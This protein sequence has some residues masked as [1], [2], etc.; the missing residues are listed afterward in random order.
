MWRTSKG[1]VG[2]FWVDL[3]DGRIYAIKTSLREAKR[4]AFPEAEYLDC[5]ATHYRGWD[6]AKEMNPRWRDVAD[7]DTVPRGRVT[8]NIATGIFIVMATPSL[9]SCETKLREEFNLIG[10]R[11]IFLYD[12]IGYFTSSAQFEDL[13]K[14]R[15]A[16][17]DA[18]GEAIPR[19]ER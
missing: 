17:S 18:D 13:F 4:R 15:N 5:L 19:R 1:Y 3:E 9:K 12:V 11:F 14:E 10:E 6:R 16:R 7:R 8:W 2:I